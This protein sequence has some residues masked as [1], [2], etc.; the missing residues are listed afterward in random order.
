VT[1]DALGLAHLHHNAS[2]L[3]FDDVVGFTVP[4]A[5]RPATR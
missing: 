5:D 4:Q 3:S 2:L 1:E